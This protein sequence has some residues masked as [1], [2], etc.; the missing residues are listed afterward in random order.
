MKLVGLYYVKPSLDLWSSSLWG[1]VQGSCPIINC[2]GEA[3][4][5]AGR[6]T[7]EHATSML[8]HLTHYNGDPNVYRASVE[9]V[10][11]ERRY[12][13]RDR[14]LI[15]LETKSGCRYRQR[16]SDLTSNIL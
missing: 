12:T 3:G 2:G 5:R 6:Q 8:S 15:L 4:N 9:Q 16:L 14:H 11:A 13:A 7:R 10:E 1:M